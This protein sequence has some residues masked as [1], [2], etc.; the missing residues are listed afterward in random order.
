MEDV[1]RAYR[2]AELR[3]ELERLEGQEG[4]FRL[5]RSAPLLVVAA[6]VGWVVARPWQDAGF[7]LLGGIALGALGAALLSVPVRRALRR[8]SARDELYRLERAPLSADAE[9]EQPG[10]DPRPLPSAGRP[11]GREPTP[12]HG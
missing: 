7:P 5:L 12:R 9:R 4:V 8:S 1:A 10:I 6:V 11:P 3:D 2:R